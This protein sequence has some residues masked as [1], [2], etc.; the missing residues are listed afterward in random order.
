VPLAR[1]ASRE[2]LQRLQ[3]STGALGRAPTRMDSLRHFL[4]FAETVLDKMLAVGGR[5]PR[6]R[7]RFGGDGEQSLKEAIE[8]GRGGIIATAHVGCLE[9]MQMA[10]DWREGLRV[11]AL[12]HTAHAQRFNR[13][14]SRLNPGLGLR[15]V[16]V[17]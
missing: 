11:T 1:R 7:V 10:A 4:L 5:Y 13:I 12:V 3:A 15:L 14:L 9:L 8:T 16:Q 2:Y 6:E 17:T